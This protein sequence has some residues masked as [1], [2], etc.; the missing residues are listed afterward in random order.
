MRPWYEHPRYPRCVSALALATAL[1]TV[2]G[3]SCSAQRADPATKIPATAPSRSTPVLTI[4]RQINGIAPQSVAYTL[5]DLQ[6]FPYSPRARAT[7]QPGVARFLGNTGQNSRLGVPLEAGNWEVRWSQPL[8]VEGTPAPVLEFR[9]QVMVQAGDWVLF[10]SDGHR[11][12]KGSMGRSALTGDLTTDLFYLI[13][14]AEQFEARSVVDGSLQFRVPIAF[15]EAFSYPLIARHGWRF[16]IAGVEHVMFGH[17]PIPA[18]QGVLFVFEIAGM[19]TD[20][21]RLLQSVKRWERLIFG[22]PQMLLAIAGDRT[23]VA[24]PGYLTYVSGDLAVEGVFADPELDPQLLSVDEN[25]FAHIVTKHGLR[26]SLWVVSPTGQRVVNTELPSTIGNIAAPPA[27]GYDH[28][29]FL[30]DS[31][32]VHA[33]APD[34]KQLWEW[35]ARGGIAGIG[36]TADDQLLVAA[37]SEVTAVDA[38]GH[39]RLLHR[40]DGET[41]AAPPVLAANGD[42]LIQTRTFL[43]RLGAH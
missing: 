35:R 26:R 36:L 29:I 3:S 8:A 14:Q 7:A 4:Q 25:N 17:P 30:W 10:S 40:F 42:L 20:P 22:N 27:I 5:R 31:S 21:T 43:H 38:G 6:N 9:D 37:G 41:I 15:G 2:S 13:N 1:C 11:L 34:G 28:R 39:G 24:T 23:A 19:K 18:T 16:Y 32:S 33:Y 12:G